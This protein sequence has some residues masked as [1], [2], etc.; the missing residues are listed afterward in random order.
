MTARSNFPII[1]IVDDD[2]SVRESLALLLELRGY[3]VRAF[4]D[5]ASFLEQVEAPGHGCVLL[6]LRMPGIDG[7]QVQAELKARGV[8][9][10]LVILTAHGDVEAARTAFKRGAFDFLEK[11]VDRKHLQSVIESALLL[12]EEIDSKRAYREQLQARVAKLTPREQQVLRQVIDGRHNREIAAN[13]K[14]SARTV[15]G[16]KARLMDKLQV[17][18]LADLIRLWIDIDLPGE[19]SE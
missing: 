19:D 12:E 5:G 8:T 3:S 1:Y 2:Q 9:M 11:P 15:E 13:L 6:D 17:D 14:L 16:Y 7:F 18:R 4:A 10:P